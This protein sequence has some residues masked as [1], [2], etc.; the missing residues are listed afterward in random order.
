M[1][2]LYLDANTTNEVSSGLLPGDPGYNPDIVEGDGGAGFASELPLYVRSDNA[3]KRYVYV[4]IRALN[5]DENVDIKYA[6]DNNGEPGQ[7]ADELSLPDINNATTIV[8]IWRKVVV[9]GGQKS[10]NRIDIKH[11]ISSREYAID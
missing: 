2:R 5:D 4:K 10:Q 1:L 6:L 11:E 9:K 3:T 8:K 7:Y